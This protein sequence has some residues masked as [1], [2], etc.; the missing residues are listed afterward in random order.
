M[1]RLVSFLSPCDNHD[2]NSTESLAVQQMEPQQT[3]LWG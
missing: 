1:I 2:F 3:K